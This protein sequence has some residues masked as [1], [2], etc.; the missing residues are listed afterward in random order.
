MAGD[1]NMRKTQRKYLFRTIKKNSISFVAVALIAAMTI[2]LFMGFR[3]ASKAVRQDLHGYFIDNKL[4]TLQV[5]CANGI[6]DEDLNAIA[7]HQGVDIVEGGYSSMV[8][9]SFENEKLPIQA[10]SLGKQVNIPVVIEGNL[11]KN[12][13][14]VA[15][16]EKLS[17]RKNINVGDSITLEHDGSL[18]RDTFVVTAI[19]N[20]PDYC[21]SVSTE[22]RGIT[23]KGLGAADFYI[24]FT[25]ESFDINY[26]QGSYTIAR[27]RNN[28]LDNNYYFSK[29]YEKE[30]KAFLNSFE[31]FAC[32]RADIRYETLMEEAKPAIEAGLMS[33]GEIKH[34]DWVILS[35]EE[36]GDLC[37]ITPLMDVCNELSL[38]LSVLFLFVTLIVC[39]A[40]TTR[41]I[42]EQRELIGAQKAM[43]FSGKEII[44]QYVIYNLLS[45]LLAVVVSILTSLGIQKIALT[46]YEGDFLLGDIPLLFDWKDTGIVAVCCLA[47]FA[48]MSYFVSRMT[49]NKSATILMR[50]EN[51]YKRKPFFFESWTFYKKIRLYTRVM[52]KNVLSEKERMLTT[53]VGVVG[54]MCMMVI[55]FNLKL[56]ITEANELQYK[57]YYLFNNRIIVDTNTGSVDEFEK[58]LDNNNIP[59]TLVQDKAKTMKTEDGSIAICRIITARD[60]E[61]I[62]DFINLKDIY[63]EETVSLPKDGLLVSRKCAEE[64][65]MSKGTI[66]KLMD[67]EGNPKEFR[68]AGVIEHYH[69]YHLF[70]ASEEYYEM[71]MEE[72]ADNSVLMVKG[73]IEGIINELSSLE[74]YM[75]VSDGSEYV[76]AVDIVNVVIVVLLV[77]SLIVSLLVILNQLIIHINRKSRELAVIRING[78]TIKETK[79]Y[80][81][82]DN[83]VL[84]VVGML[85]GNVIGMALS[86]FVI[87]IIESNLYHYVRSPFLLATVYACG[88]VILFS[89]IVNIIGLRK[90]KTLN[91][92][93]VSAN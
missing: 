2:S 37:L 24:G 80:V 90:I 7:G 85:I 63:T 8:V 49:V 9:M 19:I 56:S 47:A 66:V 70:V 14:E 39:Y 59:Y 50:R 17:L 91:M 82:K 11:P 21:S 26:Y 20:C 31:E 81:Y 46:V 28:S 10:L 29:E 71:V 65:N 60:N 12:A 36:I 15:I 18:V 55:S 86:R 34:K 57:D 13:G 41:I 38:T 42:D 5:L 84:T 52:I 93:N 74:G 76:I 54:S 72:E 83:I 32:E 87:S 22:A 62:K 68:I 40:T 3:L 88:F 78:Y 33:E 6:T 73:N 67:L 61:T 58:L 4:E 1:G 44:G 48:L 25:K 23:K 16:E 30:E 69:P 27:V 77:L 45:G 53:V 92:T 64:Y 43:G 51:V 75:G 89:L 35:R 79:A